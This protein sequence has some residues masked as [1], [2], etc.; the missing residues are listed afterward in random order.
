MPL[1]SSFTGLA[2]RLDAPWAC[3]LVTAGATAAAL[4]ATAFLTSVSGRPYFFPLFPAI[5]GAALLCGAA[6]GLL[7]TAIYV[8]AAAYWWVG[9][10]NSFGIA[11]PGDAWRL[12]GL[13]VS[14]VLVAVVTGR[15]RAL[16]LREERLRREAEQQVEARVEAERALRASEALYRTLTEAAPDQTYVARDDGRMEVA[17]RRWQEYTGLT[18]DRLTE[19]GLGDAIHP[20]DLPELT[21]RWAD[22]RRTGGAFEAEYRLRARDGTYRWFWGRALPAPA[23]GGPT[24]WVGAA[25]DIEDR[26]RAEEAIRRGAARLATLQGLTAALSA[27]RAPADVASVFL[28]EGLPLVE[29]CCG[30][31]YQRAAGGE[32]TVMRSDGHAGAAP[33]PVSEGVASP[34]LDALRNGKAVWLPDGAAM[35]VA[36]PDH[37][38]DRRAHGEVASAALP[39]AGDGAILG[40]IALSFPSPRAFDRAERG[41][42]TSVAELCAQALDRARLLDAEQ[43]A[44]RRAEEAEEAARRTSRLQEQLMGVV[45]HDLR[46]PLSSILMAAAVARRGPLSEPQASA[47]DRI[48]RSAGRMTDIIRDLLDVVRAR[49]G[50]GIPVTK[51][52]VDVEATC[53]AALAELQQVHPGRLVELVAHGDDRIHADPS[54]LMQAVSNLVGNALQHGGEEGEVTVRVEGTADGVTLTVHNLGPPIPDGVMRELFEPFH[55]GEGTSE[56]VGL[57]LFIVREIARAH[58]GRVTASSHAAHG[59]TFTLHLPRGAAD[60]ALTSRPPTR[61][62]AS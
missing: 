24:R 2:R 7:T 61:P 9:P 38:S 55:R 15:V 18:P 12:G 27:A 30:A 6:S 16:A 42:L 20:D 51:R 31:V 14:A 34:A 35:D 39:L 44:R 60:E 53:R 47:L 46:T 8:G 33:E 11:D 32:V 43:A 17:N 25:I 36:Y 28:E 59:T 52:E 4:G 45:G 1:V 56:S 5:L 62:A 41:W 10:P 26:K 49:S 3:A 58:G 21:A 40:A 29:A 50:H 48:G 13:A 37:A 54:R 22:A 23:D 19:L 57:G